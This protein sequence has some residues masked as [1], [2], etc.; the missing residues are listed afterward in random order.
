MDNLSWLKFAQVLGVF[1]RSTQQWELA[2]AKLWRW[3]CQGRQQG[4]VGW[5]RQLMLNP[6]NLLPSQYNHDELI[7]R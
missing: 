1:V 4:W 5:L 6:Q 3:Y 2:Q 7:E